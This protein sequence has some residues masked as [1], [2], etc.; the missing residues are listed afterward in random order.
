MQ[1]VLHGV[2]LTRPDVVLP[3]AL[4]SAFAEVSNNLA[5]W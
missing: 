2:D 5:A 3:D 1:A 4:A